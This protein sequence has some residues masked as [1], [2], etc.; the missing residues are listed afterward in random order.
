VSISTRTRFEIF[1]RD[2][3]TCQYCGRHP[4][5]IILHCDHILAVSKG[6]SD[7]RI[8]LLTSCMDCNLGKSN[9]LLGEKIEPLENQIQLETERSEQVKRY[10][11]FLKNQRKAVIQSLQEISDKYI[12]LI[13]ENPSEWT[14]PED[15]Q[16]SCR[17]FL[18]SLPSEIIVE[19]LEKADSRFGFSY[20]AK[21]TKLYFYG[22][23]WKMIK[24]ESPCL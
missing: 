9:K 21:R 13:G 1:K 23:C 11:T 22:I 14:M 3:F 6:G 16:K 7:E 24:G 2:N 10:N 5:Q 12:L 15:V 8:N 18:R 4:P 20:H 19:N 17:V